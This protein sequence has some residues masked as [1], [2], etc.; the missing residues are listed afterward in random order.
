VRA[1]LAA[2][3]REVQLETLSDA[4]F[5]FPQINYRARHGKAYGT[6]WGARIGGVDGSGGSPYASEIVKV[7][8]ES[9]ELLRHRDELTYGEPVFVPRPGASA[10]D[11]GV[12][13]TVGSHPQRE[14]SRL[15]VLD[16]R[17]LAPLASLSVPLSLPLGFHGN[18]SAR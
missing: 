15:S 4:R 2:G 18:F 12:L 11:D 17:T 1:R 8:V 13:L 9:G 5:E 7:G 10:E 16:A 14:E 6:V 3:K